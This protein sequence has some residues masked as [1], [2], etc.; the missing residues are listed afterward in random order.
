MATAKTNK[1]KQA[2]TNKINVVLSKM[3]KQNDFKKVETK[4]LNSGN[5]AY[6]ENSHTPAIE[7]GAYVHHRPSEAVWFTVDAMKKIQDKLGVDFMTVSPMRATIQ[8]FRKLGVELETEDFNRSAKAGLPA[9]ASDDTIELK[10]LQLAVQ[11][12]YAPDGKRKPQ[13]SKEDLIQKFKESGLTDEQIRK[14]IPSYKEVSV[15]DKLTELIK[16][17]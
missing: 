2:R 10:E 4:D 5:V 8:A 7:N 14:V 1:S 17:I 3:T 13:I 12:L 16:N 6:F 11:K 9:V 15:L